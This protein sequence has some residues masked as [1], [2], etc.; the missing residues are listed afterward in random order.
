[1]TST[2]SNSIVTESNLNDEIVSQCARQVMADAH[3]E[4]VIGLPMEDIPPNSSPARIPNKQLNN[5]QRRNHTH[6]LKCVF[7]IFLQVFQLAFN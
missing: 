5:K 7:Q 2:S 4:I 1:M 6:K 3:K